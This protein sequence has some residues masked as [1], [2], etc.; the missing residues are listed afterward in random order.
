MSCSLGRSTTI[1][2]AVIA[3]L[4][5]AWLAS[6]LPLPLALLVLTA[7]A[8]VIAAVVYLLIRW[9]LE[10]YVKYSLGDDLSRI[11]QFYSGV[12]YSSGVLRE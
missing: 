5:T 10:K 12:C 1:A 8:A 6:G 9:G 4:V 3:L 11:P 2:G 7:V